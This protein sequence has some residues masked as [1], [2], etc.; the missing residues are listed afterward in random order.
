MLGT[1]VAQLVEGLHEVTDVAGIDVVSPEAVLER[2]L[3]TVIDPT[4]RR[5]LG[6]AVTRFAPTAVVHLGV[7]TR[8]PGQPSGAHAGHGAL[9]DDVFPPRC[10]LG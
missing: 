6:R 4:E 2:T 3:V 8:R 10:S 5:T 1:R 9:L 7:R